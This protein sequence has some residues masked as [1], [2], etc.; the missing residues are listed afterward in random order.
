MGRSGV[1]LR[2]AAVPL[3]VGLV[4]GSLGIVSVPTA[5]AL[6][7]HRFEVAKSLPLPKSTTVA[8]PK[9]PRLTSFTATPTA[10]PHARG[11]VQLSALVTGTKSCVFSPNPAVPAWPKRC[12]PSIGEELGAL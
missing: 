12:R 6:P 9:A 3:A 8:K 4:A 5:F 7:H 10:L 2:L 11:S 1:T